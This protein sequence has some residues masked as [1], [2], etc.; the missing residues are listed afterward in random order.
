MRGAAL[1]LANGNSTLLAQ[2][3]DEVSDQPKRQVCVCEHV[4]DAFAELWAEDLC[5]EG[6]ISLGL[7]LALSTFRQ[8]QAE[9]DAPAQGQPLLIAPVPGE[10]HFIGA[11]LAYTM[12]SQAG[13]T[14]AYEFPQTDAD[15]GRLL[16][17]QPFS[18]LVLISSGVF[19]RLHRAER[20]HD[21]VELARRQAV[22]PL[23]I[24]LYGRLAGCADAAART[25][26]AD[27]ACCSALQ[28]HRFFE[29]PG[30]RLH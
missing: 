8:H 21:T 23:R 27:G 24:V 9:S 30:H 1:G 10:P 16:G 18:G 11:S 7:A 5:N 17:S 25:V 15:L 28:V 13:R 4:V 19:S 12:L 3:L 26:G 2:A 20:I 29:P 22:K 14:V 6:Q